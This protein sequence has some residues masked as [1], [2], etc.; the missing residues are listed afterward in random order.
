MS[1]PLIWTRVDVIILLVVLLDVDGGPPGASAAQPMTDG[2]V[3]TEKD[4]L[5]AGWRGPQPDPL[6]A[7]QAS[8]L[9]VLPLPVRKEEEEEEAHDEQDGG[10]EENSP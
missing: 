4:P 10:E 7:H 3:N 1:A 9:L 8:F 2:S 6:L 5:L